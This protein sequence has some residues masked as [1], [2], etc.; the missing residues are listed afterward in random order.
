MKLF[1]A[2]TTIMVLTACTSNDV[3]KQSNRIEVQAECAKHYAHISD[4]FSRGSKIK[5][6]MRNR[7]AL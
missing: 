5:S 6:C 2:F 4:E 3:P 7:G 1:L